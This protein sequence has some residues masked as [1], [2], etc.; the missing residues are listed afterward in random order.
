MVASGAGATCSKAQ[1]TTA[2]TPNVCIAGIHIHIHSARPSDVSTV[3][4]GDL[5]RMPVRRATDGSVGVVRPPLAVRVLNVAVPRNSNPN[6][7]YASHIVITKATVAQN[8]APS[9]P[10]VC[11]FCT[12]LISPPIAMEKAAPING[13]NGQLETSSVCQ[14]SN[15][16]SPQP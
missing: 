5:V 16:A 12:V 10:T 15:P 3:I 1:A 14:K 6:T 7:L 8:T 11:D 2:R 9:M 4:S 13:R